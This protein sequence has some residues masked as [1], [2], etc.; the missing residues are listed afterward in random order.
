MAT[1]EYMREYFKR[2]GP[3]YMKDMNLRRYGI[4]LETYNDMLAK[5]NGVCAICFRGETCLKNGKPRSLAVDHCH[6]TGRVRGLLC[7]SCNRALG[8]M[9]DNPDRLRSAAAYLERT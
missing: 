4:D 6:D 2:K 1:A 7:N 8:Y 3:E 9:K 5:Q